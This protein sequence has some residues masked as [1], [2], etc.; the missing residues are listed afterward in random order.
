MLCTCTGRL[1]SSIGP[2]FSIVFFIDF[3]KSMPRVEDWKV[4]EYLRRLRYSAQGYCI[5]GLIPRFRDVLWNRLP[6]FCL[7][8][9]RYVRYLEL[10]IW[11][12]HI[13]V[14]RF[15]KLFTFLSLDQAFRILHVQL[16]HEIF[17]EANL[18]VT[19]PLFCSAQKDWSTKDTWRNFEKFSWK[20]SFWPI[21]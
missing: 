2:Y 10:T 8:R 1:T 15:V 9:N 3:S 20:F 21:M 4:G 18:L 7:Q 6:D 5:R 12:F 19:L 17:E 16:G 14:V 13:R 11:V